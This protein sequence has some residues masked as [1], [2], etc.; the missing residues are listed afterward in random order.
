MVGLILD[1]TDREQTEAALRELNATLEQRVAERTDAL[2]HEVAER[3]QM[4]AALFQREKLAAMGS[5]L[6][7]VAHELNNPLP[8]ILLHTGLLQAD[9]GQGSWRSMRPRFPRRPRAVSG[10]CVSFSPWRASM[11]PSVRWWILMPC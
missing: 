10:W 9:A 8:I 11:H 1:I 5:L 2:Q 4:Q 7:S 3:Q 6:A